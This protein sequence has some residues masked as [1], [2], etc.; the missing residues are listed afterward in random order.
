MAS[1]PALVS[2]DDFALRL[3]GLSASDE[4]RAQA[5]LDDASAL[6][7]AE[8]GDEDW[9]DDDGALEEVPGVVVAVCVAASIRAFRNPEGVRTESIGTYSVAYADTST[10]VF[11]TEGERRIVRRAAGLSGIG[12]VQLEGEWSTGFD[13]VYVPVEGGGDDFPL[14]V[15]EGEVGWRLS[16]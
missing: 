5:C 2:L 7:R 6:I 16:G 15:G 13:A 10:A 4:D 1:S 12:S 3:G 8:A 14:G 11:L 9:V